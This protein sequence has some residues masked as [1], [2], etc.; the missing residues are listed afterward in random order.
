MLRFGSEPFLEC[1]GAGDK[2]FSSFYA[3]VKRHRD[4][5]ENLYQAYKIFEDGS[6]GLHW[7]EAKGK[8]PI[9]LKECVDYYSYLWDTYIQENPELLDVLD[10]YNGFSDIYGQKNHQCQ[11]AELWRI[12]ND[13][14]F[15]FL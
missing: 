8:T 5:I 12:K 2:R 11:A 14:M 7:S 13:I 10:M 6:T 4:T 3:Y 1:S 9:N 15:K